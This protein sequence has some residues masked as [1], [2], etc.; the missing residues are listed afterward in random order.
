MPRRI[1]DHPSQHVDVAFLH[2]ERLYL[3]RYQ[4]TVEE[5]EEQR[6]HLAQQIAKA[7]E[8]AQRIH[9]TLPADEP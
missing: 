7:K 4:A 1:I 8:A 3:D 9:I 5:M 2:D 6:A